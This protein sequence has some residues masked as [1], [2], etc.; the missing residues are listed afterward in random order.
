M[1]LSD[2]LAQLYP[3]FLVMGEVFVPHEWAAWTAAEDRYSEDLKRRAAVI[4]QDM[5]LEWLFGRTNCPATQ[6]E[7]LAAAHEA[8]IAALRNF[9]VALASEAFRRNI[10]RIP[11]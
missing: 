7:S 3:A 2:D 9:G 11:S 8:K 4:I 10:W 1:D 6:P 5:D